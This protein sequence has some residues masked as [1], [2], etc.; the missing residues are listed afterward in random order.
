MPQ[1][2]S[3]KKALRSS[4]R[5]RLVNDQWRRQL[6]VSLRTLREALAGTDTAAIEQ[7]YTAAQRML[8]RAARH[9]IIPVGT[10]ARKKSRLRQHVTRA[11]TRSV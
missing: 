2:N 6:R 8:D 5:R 3:A 7:A 10:A 1:T 9:H 11:T 4:Q